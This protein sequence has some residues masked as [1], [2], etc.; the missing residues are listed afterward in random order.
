MTQTLEDKIS[1]SE[2]KHFQAGWQAALDFM[3]KREEKINNSV[4]SGET[5]QLDSRKERIGDGK[6][7]ETQIWIDELVEKPKSI[8]KDVSELPD[9]SHYIYLKWNDGEIIP[10]H[11]FCNK[12][13]RLQNG[14]DVEL[15]DSRIVKFCTLTDYINNTEERLKKLEGK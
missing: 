5:K 9:Q 4:S 10:A 7:E 12:Y 3:K 1:E 14:N 11:Y 2:N 13:F 6:K 8:W 15:D